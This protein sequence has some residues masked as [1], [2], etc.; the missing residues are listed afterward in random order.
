MAL[1]GLPAIVERQAQVE[2]GPG[3]ARFELH[4][5]LQVGKCFLD[6]TLG[7]QGRPQDDDRFDRVGIH[8][9]DLA[10]L[11]NRFTGVSAGQQSIGQAD[12]CVGDRKSARSG[13]FATN[14]GDQPNGLAPLGDGSIVLACARKRNRQATV[15]QLRPA[16]RYALLVRNARA[17]RR[18]SLA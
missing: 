8:F 13:L 6:L 11:G 5:S 16:E 2:V 14:R 18:F 3:V 1:C 12:T 17:P 10:T 7:G 4:G 15:K 9:Q